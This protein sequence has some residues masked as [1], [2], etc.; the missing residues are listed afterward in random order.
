MDLVSWTLAGALPNPDAPILIDALS[1]SNS[2]SF[3]QISSR[4]RQLVA[5]LQAQGIKPG[6]CVCVNCFN[7]VQYSVLYLGIIGCGAIFTGV[8][9]A[10]TPNEL[11]HHFD[12]TKPSLL[13]VEPPMLE[14]TVTAANQ[15]GISTDKVF[16]LDTETENSDQTFRS[17]STL[18]DHG[19]KDWV[20]VE[21]P[22]T[23]VATYNST[24][25]TS[26]LPKAAMITH[27]YHVTQ[28]AS[29]CEETKYPRSRL[30][31]LPPFHAFGS[32][33]LPSSIRQG[34]PTYIM[35][36]YAEAPF[37]NSIAQY[38]ITETYIPPPVLMGLPKSALA[39]REG[40]S[41]LRSIWTG[42]ASVK[43]AQQEPLYDLLHED[44]CIRTVWGM[45]ESG[46]ITCVQDRTRRQDDSAGQLL[47][48]FDIRIVDPA[49]ETID[50]DNVSG[51]LLARCP[52]PL[53]SYI[54]NPAATADAFTAC[55]TYV[56]TGDIGYRLT[57]PATGVTSVYIV[58]RAKELI[59]V[60]GWQVSPTEIES[61]LMQHPGI[62]DAAVI[63]VK[64]PQGFEEH[65]RAYIVRK[66][67]CDCDTSDDLFVD[68][69]QLRTWLRK[70]LSGYKVPAEFVF[71]PSVPRNG[72]GKILR[73]VL[74]E[75]Q[76]QPIH[77]RV[78][79]ALSDVGVNVV[80]PPL[81]SHPVRPDGTSIL[82]EVVVTTAT[83][84]DQNVDG[85]Q[86]QPGV[87][88]RSKT[89]ISIRQ[90]VKKV[91]KLV[92]TNKILTRMASSFA[93]P[94]RTTR[95]VFSRH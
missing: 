21:D 2:L 41:S 67:V 40:L 63:G 33:V 11:S 7:D 22:D 83:A 4:V 94:L 42:G 80:H 35:R 95:H 32:P 73:R 54:S 55:K 23:T 46:W 61:E 56:R 8:N 66:V 91:K 87:G 93:H 19:E 82:V 52:H 62:A 47:P 72:T 77:R 51:E 9:P 14:K 50:A 13:I 68:E 78:D 5:G 10:Y 57:D 60:R 26:G 20:K 49:G 34:I 79:S 27:S 59:K 1:P 84:P 48:G 3:R 85:A 89:P 58:D 37:L 69:K 24:S 18:L 16:V 36:R 30:L 70:R 28:A 65:I 15:A 64:D 74:R 45:T 38:A 44:A 75:G 92:T 71:T 86:S 90:K 76:K 17:W 81:E 53:L 25:G 6:D 31:T 39:T 88:E 12:L 29:Q 43:F